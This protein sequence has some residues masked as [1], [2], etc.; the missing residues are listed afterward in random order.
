MSDFSGEDG[1]G[2]GTR[3]EEEKHG[4][5]LAKAEPLKRQRG[6]SLRH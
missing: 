1:V 5:S 6:K 2:L 3:L 4:K